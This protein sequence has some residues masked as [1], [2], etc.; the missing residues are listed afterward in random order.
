[1]NRARLDAL[2][3]FS[4]LVCGLLATPVLA[5]AQAPASPQYPAL[6]SELPAAISVPDASHNYA[7]RV[8][9]IPMRDGVRLNTVILVPKTATAANKA[10]IL[11]TRTPYSAALLTANSQSSH[12]G[13]SLY[14]YDNATDVIVDGGY[15][16]VIQ[17]VRG[18]YGCQ[19]GAA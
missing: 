18:K 11:L 17:D 8:V 16:R 2:V 7:R 1:M 19:R 10:A 9:M 14:G 12:L 4:L 3:S 13:S 5:T 6:H 15:I